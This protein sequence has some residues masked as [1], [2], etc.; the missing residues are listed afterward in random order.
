M[1][2]LLVGREL[3][4]LMVTLLVKKKVKG[5]DGGAAGWKRTRRMVALMVGKVDNCSYG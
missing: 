4:C 5:I 1:A 2:V 3:D